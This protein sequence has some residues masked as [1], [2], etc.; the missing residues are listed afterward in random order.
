MSG[1]NVDARVGIGSVLLIVQIGSG[2]L[3]GSYIQATPLVFPAGFGVG[4][5]AVLSRLLKIGLAKVLGA[6]WVL[7]LFIFIILIRFCIFG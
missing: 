2:F 1:L 3:L 4:E 5:L 7:L 6:I